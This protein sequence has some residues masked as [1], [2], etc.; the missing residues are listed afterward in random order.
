MP[1][2]LCIFG[3]H[4]VYPISTDTEQV[5]LLSNSLENYLCYSSASLS[6]RN[7]IQRDNIPEFEPDF[8]I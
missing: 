5:S 2:G 4:W 1:N 8:E 3:R 6:L 7:P